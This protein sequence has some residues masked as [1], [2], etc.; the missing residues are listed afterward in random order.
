MSEI[1]FVI[2]QFK[3]AQEQEHEKVYGYLFNQYGVYSLHE[4]KKL[5]FESIEWFIKV[6]SIHTYIVKVKDEFKLSDSEIA[7]IC[8][9]N[10]LGYSVFKN[11]DGTYNVDIYID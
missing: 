2:N 1:D 6:N 11:E 10:N 8:D 3:K 4:L 5:L 7:L 9:Y